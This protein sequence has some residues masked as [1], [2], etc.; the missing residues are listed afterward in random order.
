MRLGPRRKFVLGL[1]ALYLV[2]VGAL[3]GLM[4]GAGGGVADVVNALIDAHEAI[5]LGVFPVGAGVVL[6][7]LLAVGIAVG[8]G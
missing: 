4:D 1:T 2:V 8:D 6:F 5:G 3:V 7:V